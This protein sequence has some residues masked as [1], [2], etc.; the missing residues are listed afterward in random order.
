M[1]GPTNRGRSEE[2]VGKLDVAPVRLGR[3]GIAKQI[4]LGYR[5]ADA[6]ID[7]LRDS[8]EQALA[9]RDNPR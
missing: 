9:H 8:V 1:T 5:E 3:Q 2:Y 6:S 4:F 7:Y